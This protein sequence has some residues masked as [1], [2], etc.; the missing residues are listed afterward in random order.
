MGWIEDGDREGRLSRLDRSRGE[1]IVDRLDE[2][3]ADRLERTKA[4]GA[5]RI[6]V[7][8]VEY[9]GRRL[10]R[11]LEVVGQDGRLDLQLEAVDHRSRDQVALQQVAQRLGVRLRR[12]RDIGLEE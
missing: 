5:I 9:R 7:G 12:I 6:I 8:D 10:G 1:P 3:A 11:N 2:D 4:A